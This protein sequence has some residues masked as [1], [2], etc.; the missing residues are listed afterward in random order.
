MDENSSEGEPSKSENNQDEE[1][2]QNKTEN[3]EDY[4]MNYN[5]SIGVKYEYVKPLEPRIRKPHGVVSQRCGSSIDASG[6]TH[7]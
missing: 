2:K 7:T 4:L 5:R 3:A 6:A 1:G